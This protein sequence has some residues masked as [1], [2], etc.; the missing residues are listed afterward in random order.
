MK[1]LIT[2]IAILSIL[3]LFSCT[4]IVY[5]HDQVL[6]HYTTKPEVMKKFGIPTEKKVSDTTEDWLYRYDSIN[7]ITQHTIEQYRN[8]QTVTV[9]DFNRYKRYLVFN[10]DQKGNVIRCDFQGVDLTVKKKDTAGTILLITAGAAV[11]LGSTI[12]ITHHALDGYSPS[13]GG[14]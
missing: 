11:V 8:T 4:K 13:F 2:G 10:F 9:T 14:N 5:T 1:N 7:T 12:Y 3:S 6:S